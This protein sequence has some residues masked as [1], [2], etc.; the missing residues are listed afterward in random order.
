VLGPILCFLPYI[1]DLVDA[2]AKLDSSIKLYADDAK[3]YS[4][5][6]VGDNFYM[7]LLQ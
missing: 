4:S 7:I 2:F 5:F 1:N 3:L 6:K